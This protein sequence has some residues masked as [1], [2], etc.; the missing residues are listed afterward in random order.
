M[1]NSP[2]MDECILINDIKRK[3]TSH[4]SANPL[5]FQSLQTAL[6]MGNELARADAPKLQLRFLDPSSGPE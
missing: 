6:K 1:K 4:T 2:R 5:D 3:A